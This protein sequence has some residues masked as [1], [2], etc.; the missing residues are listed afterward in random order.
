MK[1]GL[2]DFIGTPEGQGLLSAAFGGLAGARRGQPINSL[3][4]A[5]LAGLAG[6]SGAQDRIDQQ[7]QNAVQKQYRDV[8]MQNLQS[9]MAKQKGEQ[10]W[11]AGLP[12]MLQQPNQPVIDQFNG[13]APAQQADPAK[14]QNYLMDPRSP[15]ADKLLEQ[16]L[17]PKAADFK[18]VGNSLVKIGT[19]GSVSEAYKAPEKVD[20]NQLMIPDGKGGYMVNKAFYD[21][22]AG[23]ASAGKTSLS[24]DARNYST[25]ESEQSKV[26]GKQLGEIRGNI[27]QMG[28]EA[29]KRMA[30]IDRM[31]ELL[32]GVDG[33]RFAPAGAELASA[34]ESLGIKIDPKLGNKQAAEALAVEMALKMRPPG[35]GPMTDKDFDNFLKTVPG[36]AKTPEGRAQISKTMRAAI[37][38][39]V[40]A[41]KFSR[42][43][44]KQNGGVIDDNYFDALSEFYSNTPVVTPQMPR[45]NAQ[46]NRLFQDADAIINGGR[47]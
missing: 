13:V 33:G 5:G 41:A 7:E 21:A 15:F 17:F 19:D 43:Y 47:R 18:T 38:R 12:A 9:Q 44:A 8:Q 27:T 22:K 45:S 39:D 32:K 23:I 29:P 24:V 16:R 35:S 10:E 42:D 20:M 36:L 28:I 31:D 26:Y 30:Q 1:N 4:R 46:G 40:Q 34:A 37:Q 2:L 25:Q 11:R 6:Y 3:G 14:L